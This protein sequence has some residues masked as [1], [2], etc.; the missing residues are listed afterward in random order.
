MVASKILTT[1]E[2]LVQTS[3][4]LG[5]KAF[6]AGALI[7]ATSA[8]AQ[9]GVSTVTVTVTNTSSASKTFSYTYGEGSES[10]SFTIAAGE[11]VS[12]SL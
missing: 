5:L 11:T 1:S 6:I 3:I 7:L 2:T 4:M 9:G 12:P 10:S 8:Y